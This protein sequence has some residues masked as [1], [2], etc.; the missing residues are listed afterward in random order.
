[1]AFGLTEGVDY[2][3][4]SFVRSPDDVRTARREIENRGG[5][6]PL[7]AKIETQAAVENIDAI[8]SEADGVMIARGDLSIETPFTRVPALQKRIIG[9]ANRLAKPV[10][11]ATQMLWSMVNSPRPTRAEVADVANAVM[12]G[13]DAVMLSEETAVGNFPVAAVK[14]MDAIVRA[15]EDSGL[16]FGWE[17]LEPARERNSSRC[18]KE[19]LAETG[20]RLAGQLKVDEITTI[21]RSGQMARFVSK[22]RPRQPILAVTPV[23]A[24][25][26]RLALVRGV[27]PLLLQENPEE[28]DALMRAAMNLI[29][30]SGWSGC[31]SV[32]ISEETVRT[33]MV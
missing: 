19:H 5:S 21:T 32:F 3:G 23:E 31:R 25:F 4:L 16:Q 18:Q 11:T 13:T 6:T 29:A 20:C 12:D 8:L 1:M 10:I 28:W 7:I 24:T 33:G 9:S 22:Y 2:V 27:V 30:E 17:E 14:T 26:R 15:A